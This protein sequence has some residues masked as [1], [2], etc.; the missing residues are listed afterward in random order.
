TFASLLAAQKMEQL[1][2]LTWSVD[3]G[4]DPVTD[5]T[6][7][8][9]GVA[10]TSGGRGLQSSPAGALDHNVAGYCD[11]LARNGA[12][13]GGGP[14]PPAAAVFIRRWSIEPLPTSPNTT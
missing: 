2:S 3:A 1:R 13:L 11:F 4:G 14:T 8:V 9:A 6:T 10:E 7:D 5:T 12:P